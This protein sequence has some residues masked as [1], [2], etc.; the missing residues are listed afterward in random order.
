MHSYL[1]KADRVTIWNPP[2]IR[3]L[4]CLLWKAYLARII[5]RTSSASGLFTNSILNDRINL[6]EKMLFFAISSQYALVE[7]HTHDVTPDIT[8]NNQLNVIYY[9]CR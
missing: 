3:I 4:L 7:K 6:L 1:S 9:D 8:N 2:T 5:E